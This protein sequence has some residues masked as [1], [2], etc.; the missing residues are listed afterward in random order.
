[1]RQ[2][3][4]P[5][6][7]ALLV[8]APGSVVV[9]QGSPGADEFAVLLERLRKEDPGVYDKVVELAKTDRPAATIPAFENSPVAQRS[10]RC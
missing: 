9:G 7:F 10:R 2:F 1:M 5:L 4:A 8:A 6:L 3:F